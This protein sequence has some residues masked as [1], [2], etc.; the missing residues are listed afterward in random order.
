LLDLLFDLLL[1]LFFDLLIDFLWRE[2]RLAVLLSDLQ[3]DDA[4]RKL[5]RCKYVARH[6]GRRRSDTE[7]HGKSGCGNKGVAN[8][9]ARCFIL[10]FLSVMLFL[11]QVRISG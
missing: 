5:L 2:G 10:P 3:A 9:S 6:C 11:R 7:R 8:N 1:K 4:R